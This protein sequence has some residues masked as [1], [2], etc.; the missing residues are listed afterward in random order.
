MNILRN[1]TC[2]QEH[3]TLIQSNIQSSFPNLI[4][5]IGSLVI[6]RASKCTV[7]LRGRYEPSRQRL[8]VFCAIEMFETFKVG[9]QSLSICS[10]EMFET[11]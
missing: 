1:S 8:H 3:F 10:I 2:R 7:Q 6:V 5:S 11:F 4:C 9:H